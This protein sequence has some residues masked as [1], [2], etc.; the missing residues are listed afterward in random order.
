MFNLSN[1]KLFKHEH[2]EARFEGIYKTDYST[3]HN[4]ANKLGMYLV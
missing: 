2:F 4:A 1:L 3:A